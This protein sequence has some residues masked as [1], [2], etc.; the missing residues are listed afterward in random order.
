LFYNIEIDK[1]LNMLSL[2]DNYIFNGNEISMIVV[3]EGKMIL[4]S[5][6]DLSMDD[7]KLM[8]DSNIYQTAF[9][10]KLILPRLQQ[11]AQK[12]L[13]CALVNVSSVL[14]KHPN[15][16]VS[17]F[18]SAC[19]AFVTSFTMALGFELIAANSDN[20][21][22]D[23]QCLCPGPVEGLFSVSPAQVVR[24][25]LTCLEYGE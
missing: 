8:L 11:R 20:S 22:I 15:V 7:I 18:Y 19:K 12:G 9:I 16:G 2:D 5:F 24:G 14:S 17:C 1:K 3:A 10:A 4:S 13:K 23:I 6:E 21:L 25:S